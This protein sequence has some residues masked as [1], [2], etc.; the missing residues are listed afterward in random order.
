MSVAS[1]SLADPGRNLIL[2]NADLDDPKSLVE[3]VRKLITN[4]VKICAIL[5]NAAVAMDI[6]AKKRTMTPQ[7]IERSVST[8]YLGPFLLTELM[9]PYLKEQFHRDAQRI[10]LMCL[11]TRFIKKGYDA[12]ISSCIFSALN[13]FHNKLPY[14]LFLLSCKSIK[15][16]AP[17]SLLTTSSAQRFR[18]IRFAI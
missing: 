16:K 12:T 5:H 7:G 18:S 8:N 11:G 14:M 15:I 6:Y 4:S 2:I 3:F 9:L 1:S 17:S 10:R 13:A